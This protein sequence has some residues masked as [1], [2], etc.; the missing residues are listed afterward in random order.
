M[1]V[2]VGVTLVL[3]LL[4][5]PAGAISQFKSETDQSSASESLIRPL[6][7]INSF[8]GLL[9]PDN[10]SMH[11]NFSY[12]FLSGGGTGLSVASYTNTMLYKFSDPLNVRF[13]LTMQGTPFGAASAY[14]NSINGVFLSRAELN[15]HPWQNVFIRLEYNHLPA[16]FYHSM[17]DPWYYGVPGSAEESNR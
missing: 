15:Y 5:L 7:S 11:H 12:S 8:L 9:N 4:M 16:G 17:Y 14:Q 2:V 1:K 6:S 3:L 13:D 10:F